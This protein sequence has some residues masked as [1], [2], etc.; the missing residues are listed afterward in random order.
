MPKGI[1][2]AYR[3]SLRIGTRMPGRYPC[4]CSACGRRRTLRK[5]PE[6]YR[7]APR[8]KSRCNP[9]TLRIDW[10]RIAAEWHARPCT[11]DEYTFPHARGRGYCKH[12]PKISLDDR[13]E[14]YDQRRW[15]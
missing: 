13:E 15:A 12:N 11:C 6:E 9:G 8:C 2:K 14:R 1:V 10:Y 5:Q 7:R 3:A 4:R